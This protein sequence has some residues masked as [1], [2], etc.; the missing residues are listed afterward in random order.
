MKA[1]FIIA[2]SACAI[3]L[4][5]VIVGKQTADEGL[6]LMNEAQLIQPS[7]KSGFFKE[8]ANLL[9]TLEETDELPVKKKSKPTMFAQTST[10]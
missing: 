7:D 5:S 1:I 10:I 3:K 9:N 6:S 8:E 4:H 2:N